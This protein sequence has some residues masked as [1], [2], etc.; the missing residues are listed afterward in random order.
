MN[1]PTGLLLKLSCVINLLFVLFFVGKQVYY[2]NWAYFHPELHV[3][4][5]QTYKNAKPNPGD[6]VFLGTSITA[7]FPLQDE[8]KRPHLINL[9]VYG[10]Q[11]DIILDR[12][13]SIVSRKPKK[14]F[15]EIGINDIRM[16]VK[17]ATTFRRYRAILDILSKDTI[18][19]KAYIQS[20]LPTSSSKMNIQVNTYNAYLKTLCRLKGLT[21]L[22]LNSVFSSGNVIDSDLTSDGLHL[23]K[24]GYYAWRR[25]IKKYLY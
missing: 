9:G 11:T 21:Y 15:L 2:R 16:N 6:L 13:D 10:A 22:D 23:S 20:I 4:N 14:I 17:P 8:L 24:T 18:K 25:Y 1:L 5:W 3:D 19:T 7:G 12:I